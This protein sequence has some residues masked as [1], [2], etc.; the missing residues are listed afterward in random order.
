M[1][2]ESSWDRKEEGEEIT[3]ANDSEAEDIH[4]SD[5]DT[6]NDSEEIER[7]TQDHHVSLWKSLW[8]LWE[9]ECVREHWSCHVLSHGAAARKGSQI[10]APYKRLIDAH[11]QNYLQENDWTTDNLANNNRLF[12]CDNTRIETHQWHYESSWQ[13]T[14][15]LNWQTTNNIAN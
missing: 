15:R 12:N 7:N 1:E 8:T 5:N 10:P 4:A 6:E 3:S 9:C 13:I 2:V 11:K 14:S